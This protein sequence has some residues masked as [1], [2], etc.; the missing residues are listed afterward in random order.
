MQRDYGGTLRKEDIGRRVHLYGWAWRIRDHGGVLFIDLRDTSGICQVVF[1][2]DYNES[3]M[4]ASETV[5]N[6]YVLKVEGVV[7]ARSPETVNSKLD[8]GEVEVATDVL[9]ILNTSEVVPLVIED[10][11]DASE[12]VR[13][14]YRYLDLRRP[15]VQERFKLR[16][17]MYQATRRYLDEKGFLE[18]ETPML[19]KST[20][21]GAR[22]F[23]VPCRLFRG[24]FYALPQSP[25][26]FKQLFMISGLDRYFQI[27]KCF[28]DEDLRGDR[29][30]EFTQ[31]DIEMSFATAEDVYDLVDGLVAGILRE[32]AGV[33]VLLPVKR[34]TYAQAM[35]QYGT[36]KP[37]TRFGLQ[38]VEV[39][40]LAE[41]S[42][43]NVFS[44]TASSGG[45]VSGINLKGCGK[46]FSRKEIDDLIA[47]CQQFGA[48]GMAYFKA[49]EKGLEGTIC[50]FFSPELLEKFKQ[51]FQAKPGDLIAFVAD[52]K[53]TAY[54]VLGRL[55][56][57]VAKKL[58]LI[59][60]G[61]HELLWV[62]DF[63]LFELG[64][65]GNIAPCH[66]PFTSPYQEEMDWL[67]SDPLAMRSKAYDL[68]LDGSEIASGSVRI[69]RREM[70]EMIFTKLGIS[71]E[72][73]EE[74]FGFFLEAFR[75]G[76]P[77][78]AGLA[79]GFDR[80]VMLLAGCDN[81]REVIAFPKTQK[82]AC[83]LTGAPTTVSPEQLREVGIEL[84]D[85][86]E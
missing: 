38:L 18:I 67:D 5:R 40:D 37:D 19:A 49:T 56:L 30:P 1:D 80:L 60:K 64:D 36:D 22:D 43:F 73:A 83:L 61:Q 71:P 59:P 74:R 65:D 21:E 33:D 10:D 16:H 57:H 79:I 27:V 58:N 25:Q 66:H 72:E 26:L 78:H 54:D 9:E 15:V 63:P 46:A 12:E 84:A 77:P 69:H 23:V 50:K 53:K 42:D 85:N 55:R 14:R 11:T 81:I 3:V 6:E 76:A 4:A 48:K 62:V 35:S 52:K 17:R 28:R 34:M 68:V 44:Q 47:F 13:L 51:R 2:R 75:Y 45:I 31:I 7:R 70:Q 20:P 41:E 8:T 82:G 39:N 24:N 29:Q 32:A 86:D